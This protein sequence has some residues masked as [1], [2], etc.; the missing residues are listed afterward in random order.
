M[1]AAA[2]AK[3]YANPEFLLH[4]VLILWVFAVWRQRKLIFWCGPLA[5]VLRVGTRIRLP[6][7]L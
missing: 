4:A 7:E 1:L 2:P 3:K 5:H 6:G